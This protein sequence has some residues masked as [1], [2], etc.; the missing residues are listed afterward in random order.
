MYMSLQQY[1]RRASLHTRMV[2][3]VAVTVASPSTLC[4]CPRKHHRRAYFRRQNGIHVLVKP[5]I[6]GK[7]NP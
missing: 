2:D 7:E 6:V 1:L 4:N 5:C 3:G